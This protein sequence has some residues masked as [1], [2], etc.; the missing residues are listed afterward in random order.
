MTEVKS[1]RIKCTD[2][3]QEGAAVKFLY[4][5]NKNWP[6][7]HGLYDLIVGTPLCYDVDADGNHTYF[8]TGS[9]GLVCELKRNMIDPVE[10]T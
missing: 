3:T 10:N 5:L 8:M 4:E 6:R 2:V 9:W 1:Y 7:K